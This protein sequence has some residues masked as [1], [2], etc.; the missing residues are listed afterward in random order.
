MLD[1]QHH[2]GVSRGWSPR[3]IR[4]ADETSGHDWLQ[5]TMVWY[6][7]D[8]ACSFWAGKIQRDR[9]GPAPDCNLFSKVHFFYLA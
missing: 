7:A 5:F 8:A 3:T 9:L 2:F 6:K 4:H 1:A